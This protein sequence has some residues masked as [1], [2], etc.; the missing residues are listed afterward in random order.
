M[1]LKRSH[2]SKWKTADFWVRFEVRVR[3]R[4]ELFLGRRSGLGNF[5]AMYNPEGGGGLES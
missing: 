3:L 4:L 5:K 1:Q 2:V